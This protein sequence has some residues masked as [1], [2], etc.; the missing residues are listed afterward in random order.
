MDRPWIHFVDI[1]F[2]HKRLN[3]R[4]ASQDFKAPEETRVGTGRVHG[5]LKA[6]GSTPA[7]VKS[8]PECHSLPWTSTVKS[9][10]TSWLHTAFPKENRKPKKDSTGDFKVATQ[11]L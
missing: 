6:G 3:H 11:R 8:F 5:E 1:S 10:F 2:M 7:A 4:A 9:H